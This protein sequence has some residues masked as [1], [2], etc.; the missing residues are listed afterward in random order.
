VQLC[1]GVLWIGGGDRNLTLNESKVL[2]V[3]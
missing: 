1:V 3:W 2:L